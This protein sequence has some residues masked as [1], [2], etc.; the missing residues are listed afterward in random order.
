MPPLAS[1][2]I[3]TQRRRLDDLPR[4]W[5]VVKLRDPDRQAVSV[6]IVLAVVRDAL[7]PQLEGPRAK[8]EIA[9]EPGTDVP[10]LARAAERRHIDPAIDLT[11]AGSNGLPDTRQIGLSIRSSRRRARRAS[12]VR[13]AS[14]ELR[15]SG[16]EAIAPRAMVETSATIAKTPAARATSFIF[17]SPVKLHRS[18]SHFDPPT[19]SNIEALRHFPHIIRRN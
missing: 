5:V 3:S 11:R 10:E 2:R 14:G 17:P 9:L 7:V 19:K 6:G 12:L 1:Y 4:L 8:R 16:E 18:A 15:Q 13:P